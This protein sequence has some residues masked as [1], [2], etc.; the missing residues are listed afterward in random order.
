MVAS[1]F[2]AFDL[3]CSNGNLKYR[4]GC[5]HINKTIFSVKCLL[6]EGDKYPLGS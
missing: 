3:P 6:K 2:L 4:K 5:G 1:H